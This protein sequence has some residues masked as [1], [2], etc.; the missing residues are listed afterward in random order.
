MS[1]GSGM[2]LGAAPR[3][4][5]RATL[6][7]GIGLW[8]IVVPYIGNALG[9]DVNVR[10]IIE[11]VD[12]VVPG[13]LVVA[14]ALYLRKLARRR[15]LAGEPTA[16][17]ASGVAFL[18]GFWVFATHAPLVRDAANDRLPWDAAIWHSIAALPIVGLAIWFVVRS[19]PA[20]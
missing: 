10:A 7:L 5:Q 9:L 4:A 11:F 18:A 14:A 15:R 13:V 2:T 3:E 17:L 19:I 20:P 12:H 6:L 16:L 1:T 8:T